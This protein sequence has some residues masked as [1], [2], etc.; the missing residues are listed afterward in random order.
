[1][2]NDSTDSEPLSYSEYAYA[3]ESNYRLPEE[4]AKFHSIIPPWLRRLEPSDSYAEPELTALKAEPSYQEDSIP[5]LASGN[6]SYLMTEESKEGPTG[7]ADGPIDLGSSKASIRSRY[8]WNERFQDLLEKPD[9]P[10]KFKPLSDLAT[11]LNPANPLDFMYAAKT[12]GKM[13]QDA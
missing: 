6:R 12:Y 10:A 1:M 5:L 7:Y 13:V 2:Y 8:F 4:V 9:S 11:G 3:S